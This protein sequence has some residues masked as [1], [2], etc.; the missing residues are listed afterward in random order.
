M[1]LYSGGP[2]KRFIF[3]YVGICVG[4]VWAFL[5]ARHFGK[6]FALLIFLPVAPDDFLCYWAGISQIPL[7][8]FTAIILLGKPLAIVL[9][10]LGLNQVFQ[11]Y[12][13]EEGE[14]NGGIFIFRGSKSGGKKRSRA[15]TQA[16]ADWGKPGLDKKNPEKG[17]CGSDRKW[18]SCCPG[19]CHRKNRCAASGNV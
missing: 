15:C 14:K 6:I 16:S 18:L 12:L 10:S 17:S 5:I 4:S 11:E 3:N 19:T 8:R 1:A 7:R 13:H 9:Y 2:V